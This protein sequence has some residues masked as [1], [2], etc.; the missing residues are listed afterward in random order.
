[1][2]E[3]PRA[4]LCSPVCWDWERELFL[5]AFEVRLDG[6]LGSLVWALTARQRNGEQVLSSLC[7]LLQDN[8][9]HLSAWRSLHYSG[10]E[11]NPLDEIF[12]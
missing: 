3:E 9:L 1:M 11:S 10:L 12:C 8:H 6:T 4:A 7:G 5:T 2:A